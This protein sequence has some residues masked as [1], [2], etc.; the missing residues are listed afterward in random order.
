[1]DHISYST[2]EGIDKAVSLGFGA[3]AITCH[4]YFAWTPEYSEY[5]K[6]KGLLFIPGIEIYTGET[7]A[8][9]RRHV[10]ILNAIKS[11]ENVRTFKELALYKKEANRS[12]PQ[13]SVDV[14]SEQGQADRWE[15]RHSHRGF[16][17]TGQT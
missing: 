8:E 10:L 6:Q 16:E 12:S 7:L 15:D 17:A 13:L 14:V 1:M 5:A 3:L 4:Q 9:S 11:A 2:K